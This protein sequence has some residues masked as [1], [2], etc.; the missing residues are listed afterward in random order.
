MT[1]WDGHDAGA[2]TAKFAGGAGT[3]WRMQRCEAHDH[4]AAPHTSDA[5]GRRP[6]HSTRTE[7]NGER[8]TVPEVQ[9]HDW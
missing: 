8:G 9:Q 4:A 1:R 6:R 2:I 5:R 3:R 7:P